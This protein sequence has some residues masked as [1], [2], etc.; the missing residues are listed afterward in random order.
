ME[1]E[2]DMK[3][4]VAESD[5]ALD[6]LSAVAAQMDMVAWDLIRARGRAPGESA[7]EFELRCI[8]EAQTGRT[9]K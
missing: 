6:V 9:G 3:R 2:T 4:T 8:S 7:L 5:Y 1:R